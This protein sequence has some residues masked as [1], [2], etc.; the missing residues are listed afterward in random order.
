MPS[1]IDLAWEGAILFAAVVE[2]VF[3]L[4]VGDEVARLVPTRI[5]FGCPLVFLVAVTVFGL[6]VVVRFNIPKGG[7]PRR[8][9]MAVGTAL[10][11]SMAVVAYIMGSGVAVTRLLSVAGSILVA[12]IM[13]SGMAVTR[14]LSVAGSILLAYIMGSGVAV[15]RLLSVAGSIVITC[16][17]VR[18]KEGSVAM[19]APESID[20]HCVARMK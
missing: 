6:T 9:I 3:S 16:G 12:Y 19:V 10:D 15:S 7:V 20:W 4:V 18:A 5:P 2:T 8:I 17:V 13:G 11:E 14:L 1:F